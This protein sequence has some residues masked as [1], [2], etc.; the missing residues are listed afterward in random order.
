VYLLFIES[1]R[2]GE[3]G[4]SAPNMYWECVMV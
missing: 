1:V 2:N 4:V 3:V